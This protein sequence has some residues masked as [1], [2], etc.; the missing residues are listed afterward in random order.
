MTK[1][2]AQKLLGVT[3]QADLARALKITPQA[4]GKWPKYRLRVSAVK[5]VKAELARRQ[6]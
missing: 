2:E 4:V 6:K 1:K 5:R 3:T